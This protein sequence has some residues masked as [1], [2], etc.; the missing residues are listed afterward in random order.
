[1][2]TRFTIILALFLLSAVAGA[3]KLTIDSTSIPGAKIRYLDGEKVHV[4]A[5][6]LPTFPGGEHEM[7]K[8]IRDNLIF[9]LEAQL[10]GIEGRVMIGFIVSKT[11]ELSNYEVVEGLY[12]LLDEEAMRVIKKMP[13]VWTPGKLNGKTVPFY[14]KV[15]IIF[16][17]GIDPDPISFYVGEKKIY[18]KVDSMPEYP[19]GITKM[20]Y[21]IVD[22]LRSVRKYLDT[23]VE[24]QVAIGFVV[25]ET[26]EVSNYEVVEKVHPLLDAEVLRVVKKMPKVWTPGRLNGQPV[27]VYSMV[28]LIFRQNLTQIIIREVNIRKQ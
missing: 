20:E 17:L 18:T 23:E 8:F 25:S 1:M 5:D 6:A 10:K 14:R 15:P 26:G 9:R 19:G 3:Q 24:G 2:K 27:P 11:G 7:Q 13:K 12:P 28:Y 16:K 22:N 4:R 21:F